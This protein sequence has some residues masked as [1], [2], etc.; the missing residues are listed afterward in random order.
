M[1][2]SVAF[3]QAGAAQ[4]PSV[5]ESMFPLLVIFGVMYFF[6]IRPQSKKMKETQK[7]L[8]ALKR[9]D[10]VVTTSGILGV[11]EGMTDQWITLEVAPNTRLKVERRHVAR[12]SQ[13][14]AKENN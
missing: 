12:L 9:G 14:P 4:K 5:L 2:W 10:E 1:L 6:V 8:T 7:M 11:I 13:Q 3:A